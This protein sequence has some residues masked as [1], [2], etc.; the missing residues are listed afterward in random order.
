[1]FLRSQLRN[2]KKKEKEKNS[3]IDACLVLK[4]VISKNQRKGILAHI[5]V[6]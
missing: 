2:E 5:I 3:Q 1:M 4:L 6:N